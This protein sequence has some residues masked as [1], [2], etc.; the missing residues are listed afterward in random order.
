MYICDTCGRLYDGEFRQ[1]KEAHGE[2]VFDDVCRCG[3]EFVEA[4]KCNY[5][6]EWFYDREELE[7]CEDCI[8][9]ATTVENALELGAR[10]TLPAEINGFIVDLLGKDKINEILAEWVKANIN[11]DNVEVYRYCNAYASELAELLT[12]EA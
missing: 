10:G 4:K 1:Y 9:E 5:C 11:D 12:N 2:L 8:T 7:V 6:G 3:G